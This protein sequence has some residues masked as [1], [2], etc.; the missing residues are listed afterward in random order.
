LRGLLP[1]RRP[2]FQNLGQV[3]ECIRDLDDDKLGRI[4]LGSGAGQISRFEVLVAFS[5]GEHYIKTHPWCV[6]GYS[7]GWYKKYVGGWLEKL[8]LAGIAGGGSYRPH[9]TN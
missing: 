2:T 3:D 4:A 6:A 8:K 5:T 1:G 7:D 9:N